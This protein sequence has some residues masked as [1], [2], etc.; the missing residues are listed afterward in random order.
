MGGEGDLGAGTRVFLD[1]RRLVI[2]ARRKGWG[3]KR[4]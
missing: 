1:E 4:W 3:S 2:V